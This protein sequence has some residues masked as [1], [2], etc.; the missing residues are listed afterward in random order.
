[1][2]AVQPLPR[3]QFRIGYTVQQE[4]AWLITCA[5]FFGT[6]GGGLFFVSYVA[7]FDLGAAVALLIV[8]VGKTTA[9]LLF[10]GKP[11]RAWRA[12]FAWRTSWISR[13][14]VAMSVFLACGFVSVLPYFGVSG[15]EGA[16]G[17]F[18]WIAAGAAVVLMVYD[19][20]VL[21]TSG[22]IPLWSS[23]LMPLLTLSYAL[24]GGVALTLVLEVIAGDEVTGSAVE[25]L[26]VA[27]LAANLVLVGVYVYSAPIRSAAAGFAARM[28]TRGPRGRVF[29][30]G[31]V[32][33]GLV[34]TLAFAIVAVS[35]G[36]DAALTLA[37]ATDLAG[38]FAMFF[39]ILRAGVYEP[40]RPL[41][42]PG[43]PAAGRA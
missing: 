36:S 30:L 41:S 33:I 7:D 2:A 6:V 24:L 23:W 17:V 12:V 20:F 4:W 29:L 15:L 34:A 40:P 26:E 42:L 37:A 5:F 43:V 39:L 27:L 31:A 14:V 21:K 35:T 19:G 25:L 8:G 1:M 28:L 32:G 3:S 16:A 22:G 38:H 10:L 13:G 9:H 18:G 11:L